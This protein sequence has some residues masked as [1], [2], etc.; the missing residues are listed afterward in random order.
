M[1]LEDEILISFLQYFL[2]LAQVSVYYWTRVIDPVCTFSYKKV[3]HIGNF[4]FNW[5][6]KLLTTCSFFIWIPQLFWFN[7]HH[8][9]IC[10]HNIDFIIFNPIF[11]HIWTKIPQHQNVVWKNSDEAFDFRSQNKGQRKA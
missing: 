3:K 10:T 7:F 2:S 5:N 4:I 6:T 9:L 11:L 8:D 1:F